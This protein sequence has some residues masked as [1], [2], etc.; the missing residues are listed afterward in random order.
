MTLAELGESNASVSLAALFE[1]NGFA[2]QSCPTDMTTVA[3]WCCRGGWPGS[4]DVSDGV[5]CERAMQ[6]VRSTLDINV[7]DEGLSPQIAERVLRALAFNVGQSATRP[8][9]LKDAGYEGA[10]PAQANMLDE[11]LALFHRLF[12]VNEIGGWEPPLRAKSRVRVK[13]KRYF[14][15]SS[16][17]AALLRAVP[18]ELIFDTQTLGMLFENLVMH[19]LAVFAETYGHL[20]ARLCYYRDDKGLEVDAILER[21]AQWAALEI[22]LS[23]VKVDEAAANLLRLAAK[24]TANPAARNAAPAF[25]AVVTGRSTLAYQRPDGVYVIPAAVLTA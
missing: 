5:A 10:T 15:D 2:P 7:V 13:P 12:L 19:D 23:D 8:T 11:Y 3:R 18:D 16:L 22:K 21:G 9:L 1:G 24:V 20:G 6:Y 14:A 4:R 25:L 17:A